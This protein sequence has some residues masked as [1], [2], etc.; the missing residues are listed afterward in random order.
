[1]PV[2]E[3]L[4]LLGTQDLAGHSSD[5]TS[6]CHDNLEEELIEERQTATLYVDHQEYSSVCNRDTD[7]G[8][9]SCKGGGGADEDER[10]QV[11]QEYLE[12]DML[13]EKQ[14]DEGRECKPNLRGAPL[15]LSTN[16]ETT[17]YLIRINLAPPKPKYCVS[18]T[19]PPR[20]SLNLEATLT[21]HGVIVKIDVSRLPLYYLT[22]IYL[23]KWGRGGAVAR[24]LAS[25]QGE[26][27]SI[28]GGVAPG[29]SHVGI[30][31]HDGRIFLGDLLFPRALSFRRC[32]TLTQI[33]FIGSRD[34]AVEESAKSL[35]SLDACIG[36]PAR[37]GEMIAT[38][39][40][41]EVY[42]GGPCQAAG[43]G[44]EMG[45]VIAN[46][47]GPWMRQM[48]QGLP[49]LVSFAR[50]R[51]LMENILASGC[52]AYGRA[53][54][55]KPISSIGDTSL[56]TPQNSQSPASGNRAGRR[57]CSA[58][59]LGG[60]PF[61]PP[62]HSGA[63]PLSPHFTLVGS[64]DLV[65]KSRPNLSSQ[66]TQLNSGSLR[67]RAEGAH[68]R[69]LA[70]KCG[71]R[72]PKGARGQVLVCI[73]L[74]VWGA[75][76]VCDLVLD[77]GITGHSRVDNLNC[78]RN[79]NFLVTVAK[80]ASRRI[81]IV[82]PRNSKPKGIR[83]LSV[84]CIY[85]INSVFRH[86]GLPFR[87]YTAHFRKTFRK[88]T[89]RIGSD[90]SHERAAHTDGHKSHPCPPRG[91]K[92]EPLTLNTR[93]TAPQ[94]AANR[95]LRTQMATSP[96]THART[97]TRAH[98]C[99][100][101]S[102]FSAESGCAG[103]FYVRAYTAGPLSC[104]SA[105][106]RSVPSHSL[107]STRR[108]ACPDVCGYQYCR[109]VVLPLS[110]RPARAEPLAREYEGTRMPRR[111]RVPLLHWEP[112]FTGATQHSLKL[113]ARS[114]YFDGGGWGGLTSPTLHIKNEKLPGWTR[115]L[116][117][118]SPYNSRSE[119]RRYPKTRNTQTIQSPITK[120]NLS[121]KCLEMQL[122]VKSSFLGIR[123][124]VGA[125]CTRYNPF[126]DKVANT[127]GG[128]H[129]KLP[130]YEVRQAAG[131]ININPFSSLRPEPSVALA[132]LLR[133]CPGD[134][135]RADNSF[136]NS[137]RQLLHAYETQARR[138][139]RAKITFGTLQISYKD[140]VLYTLT[141]KFNVIVYQPKTQE[142]LASIRFN[143]THN[144]RLHHRGSKLDPRSDLRSTQNCCTIR[145][146]SWIGDRDEVHFEPPKLA[147]RNLDPRSAAIERSVL[148][149]LARAC[150]VLIFRLASRWERSVLDY[151]ARACEVLIFRLASRWERSVL[152]YLARACEVLIFRLAS[153]CKRSAI[154][155]LIRRILAVLATDV[156]LERP[157][158][159]CLPA[160]RRPTVSELPN[161]DWPVKLDSTVL[162]TNMQI[163]TVHW[164]SAATVEGD[165]WASVLQEVSNTVHSSQSAEACPRILP[166]P[167]HKVPPVLPTTPF[168]NGKEEP[169]DIRPINSTIGYSRNTILFAQFAG[170]TTLPRKRSTLMVDQDLS[171]VPSV[172]HH[173]C[174]NSTISLSVRSFGQ[175]LNTTIFEETILIFNTAALLPF[176]SRA[177]PLTLEFPLSA[178][179]EY[180]KPPFYITGTL[181]PQPGGGGG[182]SIPCEEPWPPRL[183]SV[184]LWRKG[185]ANLLPPPHP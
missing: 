168:A 78:R 155:Y 149:Y 15:A 83:R 93:P 81:G 8:F 99:C 115:T 183:P 162:C 33:T 65:A 18:T 98:I 73:Q 23:T 171:F 172:S 166:P 110:Y 68:L 49:S 150:E 173:D 123:L 91:S 118:K 64:Q 184:I 121:L 36:Q 67:A 114:K 26:P 154:D 27:G 80:K 22:L 185:E 113:T 181:L 127:S 42:L 136:T 112:V 180:P 151:L 52:S 71:G 104:R 158:S 41:T 96:S 19:A 25:H 72:T 90:V 66:L 147:V 7:E 138:S 156:F 60:L 11:D 12:C 140:N 3:D 6:V 79:D 5:G 31:P 10:Q 86:H 37:H 24:V 103:C 58:G 130:A 76:A 135:N 95:S 159:R 126:G 48:C 61:P 174:I 142:A 129:A 54:V 13:N 153:R 34:L 100:R 117:H 69:E 40:L 169:R 28:P 1:M 119:L 39:A 75:I 105:T 179:E 43:S 157:V 56:E 89:F 167:V 163:S 133:T 51:P 84:F 131:H 170:L 164:L 53:A 88:Y 145:V 132:A 102:N 30:V 148:D 182:G 122:V 44:R 165:D 137:P 70:G 46:P 35:R 9:D 101:P 97:V 176:Y 38:P 16:I 111:L 143:D 59:F 116:A 55:A 21:F 47:A 32:S 63:A 17:I 161:S 139:I 45:T 175:I 152:D 4:R 120:A 177:G 50:R 20:P 125:D 92:P 134:K 146:Q 85:G 57:L 108:L 106:D 62:L 178:G 109:A 144:A 14:L 124:G 87:V 141:R 77:L 107:G 94:G 74:R 2:I 160:N 82:R 29:F 128:D